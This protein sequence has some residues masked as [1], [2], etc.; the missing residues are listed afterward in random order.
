MYS[1]LV[2]DSS[3]HKKSMVMNK[4]TVGRTKGRSKYKAFFGITNV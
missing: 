3:E 4:N 1:L 2:D